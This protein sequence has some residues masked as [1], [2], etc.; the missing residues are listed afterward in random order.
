MPTLSNEEFA[1]LT[2][3]ELVKTLKNLKREN[4]ENQTSIQREIDWIGKKYSTTPYHLKKG[5]HTWCWLSL[6]LKGEKPTS[7]GENPQQIEST[8]KIA[9]T[10]EPDNHR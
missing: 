4:F 9:P 10:N 3:R 7:E 5:K 8:K 1:I 2:A 6:T